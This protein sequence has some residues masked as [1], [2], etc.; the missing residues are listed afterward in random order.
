MARLKLFIPLIIFALLGA[1]FYSML[2]RDYN[3]QDLP[4]ALIGQ[5]LPEFSLPALEGDKKLSKKDLI[6]EPMLLNV[7]ATWCISCRVEHPYL[8]TLKQQG[9]KIVGLDYKDDREKA[10]QWLEKLGNPYTFTIYDETGKLG[11]DLGVY[12]APETYIID[13]KG[14]IRDKHVGVI[15]ETVWQEKLQP[16][17][18]QLQSEMN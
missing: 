2:S 13:A 11:L 9:I 4:S 5:A 3:P 6:G 7:W 14:M 1:V 8:N 16:L 10:L 12:G 18:Q 15:N 17:F